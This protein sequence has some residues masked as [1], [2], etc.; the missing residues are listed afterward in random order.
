MVPEWIPAVTQFDW[1]N[2]RQLRNYWYDFSETWHNLPPG[3]PQ[4]QPSQN[5]VILSFKVKLVI[6]VKNNL[7][8]K[9][10]YYIRA[11]EYIFL[12]GKKKFQTTKLSIFKIPQQSSTQQL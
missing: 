6:S 8:I 1:V 10:S 4:Q 3:K 5:K 12:N 2:D 9:K 11:D 7:I